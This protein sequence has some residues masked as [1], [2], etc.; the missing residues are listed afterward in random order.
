MMDWNHG[1]ERPTILSESRFMAC[2]REA[3]EKLYSEAVVICASHQIRN[4]NGVAF[5]LQT[6]EAFTT[7]AQSYIHNQLES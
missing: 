2:R 1:D 7:C 3:G 5:V 4:K 6:V